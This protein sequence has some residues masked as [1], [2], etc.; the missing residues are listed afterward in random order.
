MPS[1]TAKDRR[2]LCAECFPDR[3]EK[4]SPVYRFINGVS[5][6][7]AAHDYAFTSYSKRTRSPQ[8][9][10]CH[11]AEL[12]NIAITSLQDLQNFRLIF[13]YRC[14]TLEV[15]HGLRDIG[16]CVQETFQYFQP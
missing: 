15:R 2:K 3:V 8:D 6:F 9:A 12:N 4:S 11:M 1:K 5:L 13:E 14:V 16:K 7:R 10:E